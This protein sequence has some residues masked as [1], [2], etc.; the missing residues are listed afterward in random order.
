MSTR[1]IAGAD[2]LRKS[3][4][5]LKTNVARSALRHASK[6]AAVVV[7]RAAEARAPVGDMPHKTYKG[8]LVAPGFLARSIHVA[9]R[10]LS[11]KGAVLAR[12]GPAKEAFY[13][14]Q[15]VELGTSKMPARPWLVPAYEESRTEVESTFI[16]ELRRAI[17]RAIKRGGKR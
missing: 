12:I 3:L 11:R 4:E 14:T 17:V 15:F 5:S 1:T 10:Y 2:E 13:G 9:V 6:K 7:E 16:H 8:R